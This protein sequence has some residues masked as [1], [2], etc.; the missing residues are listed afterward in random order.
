M[1]NKLA[2]LGLAAVATG[3]CSYTPGEPAPQR[4]VAAVNVPVVTRSDYVFDAVVPG[5]TLP[6][7]EAAR[8]DAWFRGLELGYGDNIYVD[9]PMADMARADVARVAG[10]YG[11]MVANGAPV[12]VGAIPDSAVR[13]VV[14]RTRASVPGCPNWSEPSQPNY[15]NRMMS[16]FGCAVNSN[17][18]AMIANPQDLVIGR[19]GS[20]V[21][22]PST[23][24]R[25]IDLYRTA[26][27]TGRKGLE[28]IDTT[29]QS[30]G[31]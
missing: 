22:D 3:A 28:K 7:S 21:V 26:P 24:T 16:N 2:L 10:Q 20:G 12:T 4:G 30:G 18:A 15:N 23:A 9:G 17:M 19:E 29:S 25:A 14:S 5:G 6:A 8:L 13:V 1:R 31:K 27:P 11:L